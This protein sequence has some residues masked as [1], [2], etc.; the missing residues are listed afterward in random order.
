[1]NGALVASSTSTWPSSQIE[2]RPS[3]TAPGTSASNVVMSAHVAP[4]VVSAVGVHD[5][6][7]VGG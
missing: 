1:M 7:N 6:G 5:T 3:V 4:A 2:R